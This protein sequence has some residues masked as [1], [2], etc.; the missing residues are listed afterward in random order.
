LLGDTVT[1]PFLWDR[2]VLT[3]LGTL[4]GT[5]GFSNW[6]NEAG[7]AVGGATTP[8][9]VVIHGFLW[10]HGTMTDLGTVPGDSCSGAFAI[11]SKAQVVGNSGDCSANVYNHA[12]LWENGGPMIDLN[13]LAVSQS[14]MQ[15][16]WAKDIN[17]SGEIV[18]LGKLS[19]GDIHAFLAV[20]CQPGDQCQTG[21]ASAGQNQVGFNPTTSSYLRPTPSELLA[22]W[23][24]RMARRYHIPVGSPNK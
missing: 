6:I 12:F 14:D 24:S 21:A 17:D 19:S 11:N 9:D 5:F 3:D 20:P 8:G 15:L 10:N 18:G 2:G 16:I 13:T 1:H 4:G 23:R 22:S 7:Q